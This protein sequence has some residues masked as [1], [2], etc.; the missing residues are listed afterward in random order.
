[1][2]VQ[3]EKVGSDPNCEMRIKSKVENK[4]NVAAGTKASLSFLDCPNEDVRLTASKVIS[5][6]LATFSLTSILTK[7]NCSIVV[8]NFTFLSMMKDDLMIIIASRHFNVVKRGLNLGFPEKCNT[9]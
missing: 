1:M 5:K 3:I 6:T 7:N 4:I 9:F 2:S 8:F